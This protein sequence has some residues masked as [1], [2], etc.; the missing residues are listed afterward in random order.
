[1][2]VYIR[3]YKGVGVMVHT[4]H[5][6]HMPIL[7]FFRMMKMG[8]L[9]KITAGASLPI[10]KL[11]NPSTP[12]GQGSAF[13]PA[14]RWPSVRCSNC[15]P[16]YGRHYWRDSYGAWR[17]IQC[18]PPVAVAMVREQC[19]VGDG[20]PDGA[21]GEQLAPIASSGEIIA[22][23]EFSAYARGR[24]RYYEDRAGRHWE[25]ITYIS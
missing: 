17:C 16:P 24:W 3:M 15:L 12:P 13:E 22:G 11:T 23:E 4:V 9:Q 18:H 5:M 25:R 20:R 21:Q 8:I 10:V 1:M 7:T 6:V 14:S 2:C 19:L